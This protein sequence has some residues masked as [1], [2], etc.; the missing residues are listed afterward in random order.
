MHRRGKK[1]ADPTVSN[2][3]VCPNYDPAFLIQRQFPGFL[4]HKR[5]TVRRAGLSFRREISKD[6]R[7]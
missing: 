2:A 7:R 3:N 6:T 4:I 1:T 5:H